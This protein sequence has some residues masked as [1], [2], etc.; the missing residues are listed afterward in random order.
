MVQEPL[1]FPWSSQKVR[2]NLFLK[3]TNIYFL[4]F[5]LSF[6]Q[7]YT[8]KRF[9][10]YKIL[11]AEQMW[12]QLSSIKLDIKMI[13]KNVEMSLP[14]FFLK[15][16]IVFHK[17]IL[18]ILKYNV[19]IFNKLIFLNSVLISTTVNTDSYNPQTKVLWGSW[20]FL[21]HKGVLRPKHLRTNELKTLTLGVLPVKTSVYSI[22]QWRPQPTIPTYVHRA[23]NLLNFFLF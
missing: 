9:T 10:Y 5:S 11:K 22:P 19:F 13:H 7:K 17:N 6:S 14:I 23:L 3:N 20:S 12:V 1:R 16:Y 15:N 8:V 21:S 2:S 4:L 18:F